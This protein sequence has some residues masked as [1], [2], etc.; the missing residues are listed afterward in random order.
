[1]GRVR[2]DRRRDFDNAGSLGT[3]TAAFWPYFNQDKRDAFAENILTLL[4]KD[5]YT[6]NYVG[7]SFLSILPELA[8][9]THTTD[10]MIRALRSAVENE[11]KLVID[12]LENLPKEWVAK[13][14]REKS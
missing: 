13:I 4:H 2:A 9:Q 7:W 11:A 8:E 6:Q 12:G 5:A 10:Q 3:W 14:K 1:L